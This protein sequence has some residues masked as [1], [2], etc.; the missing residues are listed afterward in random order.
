MS[1]TLEHSPI[2]TPPNLEQVKEDMQN[3]KEFLEK[4]LQDTYVYCSIN[5]KYKQ[6]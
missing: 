6:K 4:A 2:K 5:K 1:C 3:V